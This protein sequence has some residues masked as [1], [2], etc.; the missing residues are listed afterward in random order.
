MKKFIL[1]GLLMGILS[2]SNITLASYVSPYSEPS[3]LL[4]QGA[5]GNDVKWL[6]DMCHHARLPTGD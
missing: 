5:V 2:F 6:Q 4:K 3:S 1:L